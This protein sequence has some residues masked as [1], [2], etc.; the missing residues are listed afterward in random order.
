MTF[1]FFKFKGKKP[2][3]CQRHAPKSP[4][5]RKHMWAG[6]GS[7]YIL[8]SKENVPQESANILYDIVF[9]FFFFFG[10]GGGV[11]F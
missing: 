7:G 3:Q 8:T 1:P 4:G 11:W 6:H 9:L 5:Q 10:G 2:K